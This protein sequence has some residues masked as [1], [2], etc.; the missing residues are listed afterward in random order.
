MDR[1]DAFTN[2]TDD[3]VMVIVAGI[4]FVAVGAVAEIAPADERDFLHGSE[5]SVNGH[6]IAQFGFQAPVKIFSGK[7]AVLSREDREDRGA[8]LR[9]AEA[10]RGEGSQ[11]LLQGSFGCGVSRHRALFLNR[12]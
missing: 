1:L 4:E 6:E 3:M 7:R 8:R 11:G 9:K 5:R 10:V 12:G 2:A